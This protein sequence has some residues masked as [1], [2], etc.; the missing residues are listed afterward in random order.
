MAKKKKD[1]DGKDAADEKTRSDEPDEEE[2]R[3]DLE[4]DVQQGDS[5]PEGKAVASDRPWWIRKWWIPAPIILI[6]VLLGTT[7]Y[8]KPDLLNIVTG[9]RSHVT[10]VDLTNDNLKEEGLSPF[11]IPPS[12]D[13]SRGAI[14]I[15]LTVIWDGV[16]SVRFKT[17]ELRIRSEVYDYLKKIAEQNPDL[18]SQ[19]SAMEDGMSG[20]FRK[21]LGVNDLAIRIK[22]IKLI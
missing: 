19:K 11:F 17:G 5:R 10:P 21:S 2:G 14:R 7:V 9:K 15:D 20:I 16:A 12:T 3:S 6:L 18:D 13:L 1:N 4:E 8:L 22:E